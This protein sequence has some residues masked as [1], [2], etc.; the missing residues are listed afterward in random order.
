MQNVRIRTAPDQLP[1]VGG[2]PGLPPGARGR[3][4]PAIV[5]GAAPHTREDHSRTIRVELAVHTGD[6][7]HPRGLVVDD[8]RIG[9][10]RH[11]ARLRRALDLDVDEAVTPDAVLG[12]HVLVLVGQKAEGRWRVRAY[13][14]LFAERLRPAHEALGLHPGETRRYFGVIDDVEVA[15]A[16][17]LELRL[18]IDAGEDPAAD[19]VYLAHSILC[20]R[21]THVAGV[22]MIG[23]DGSWAFDPRALTARP[24]RVTCWPNCY[25]APYPV[26]V[27]VGS[28]EAA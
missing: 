15:G 22:P 7:A 18:A 19:A 14:H 5:V 24:V 23:D 25:G 1:L 10:S 9:H 26:H 13:R 2:R 16:N 6:P 3:W 20:T 21:Q 4:L 17:R 8:L 11:V 28:I 12:A 27:L